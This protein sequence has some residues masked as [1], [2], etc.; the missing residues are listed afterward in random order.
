MLTVHGR[1]TSLNVQ[2]VM[3]GIAELD[4]AARARST[5]LR[6]RRHRHARVP[7]DEPER[8]RPG[9]PRRATSRCSRAP[10][11][12]ATSPPA[13][14]ASRS[15]PRIRSP[16]PPSTCGPSG[17]RPRCSRASRPGLVPAATR[18]A[19]APATP[20]GTRPAPASRRN[21]DILEAQLGDGPLRHRRA[22]SPSPTSRSATPLYRYF[23]ID[24][25]RRDR[26]AL[27]AYYARLTERPAYAEHVMVPYDVAPRLRRSD[28]GR[29]RHRRLRL[30]RLGAR[31][32]AR[33]GRPLGRSSSS[34]A[35]PTGARSSRCRRRSPTR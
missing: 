28:A 16:A 22:T 27:A 26:P 8:P 34:T 7:R 15:G 13:T 25:D 6:L 24:I 11:S 3:W 4:L 20:P 18:H 21:L 33:R 31:L 9:A 14:A 30:R 5:R 17:A 29:L 32:P 10:R 35:A 1:A 2:A 12:C 23:T 19:P